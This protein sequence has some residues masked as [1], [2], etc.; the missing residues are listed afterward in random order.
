MR[1]TNK[2]IGLTVYFWTNGTDGTENGIIPKT[3]YESGV[4]RIETNE[5]HGITASYPVP[6]NSLGELMSKIEK[7]LIKHKITLIPS[8]LSSKFRK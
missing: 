1:K 7:E 5:I 4:V 2:T 6:F 3:I 8:R